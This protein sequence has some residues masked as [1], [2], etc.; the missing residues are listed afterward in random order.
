VVSVVSFTF[1]CLKAYGY[2][3]V[4]SLD[5]VCFI[6]DYFLFFNEYSDVILIWTEFVRH[7]FPLCFLC[8]QGDI[9]INKM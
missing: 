8:D 9:P 2:S 7:E 6:V 1:L 5:V 3:G 4:V